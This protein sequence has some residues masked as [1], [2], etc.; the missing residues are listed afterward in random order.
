MNK[1]M[2]Q[3]LSITL[4][5]LLCGLAWIINAAAL[6]NRSQVGDVTRI[7][8]TAI[9]TFETST[10][11]LSTESPVLFEDLLQTGSG[12]RLAVKLADGSEVTLGENCSLLVDAFVYSPENSQG[13]LALDVIQGAFLFVGGKV[14]DV[15]NADVSINTPVGTLGIRGTTVWGGLIDDGFGVLTLEGEVIVSNTAGEVRLGPG[16][17]TMISAPGQ[18]PTAPKVWPEEKKTRA[19]ATVNF[20][21]N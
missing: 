16:E 12:A 17:G 8:K 20:S 19:F 9:A 10:R 7:Q 4:L 2:T 6:D 21:E 11:P 5:A 15:P 3:K 1:G 14:E 18:A 13:E